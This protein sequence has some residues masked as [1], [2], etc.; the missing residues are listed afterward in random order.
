LPYD[1][2]RD[3][4]PVS[5]LTRAP[6]LLVVP[7]KSP[8]HSVHDLVSAARSAPGKLSFA[9]AGNG[10]AQHLT[11]EL[12]KQA[13]GTSMTHV[14]YKGGAPALTDL[15]G[16]QVGLMFSAT[17]A[18]GPFVQGGKLRA[19]AVTAGERVAG[20]PAVPT[21]KEAGV[22][23]MEVYEW[24]G[25]FAPAGTPPR[26]LERLEKEVRAAVTSP[27]LQRRWTELGVQGVGSS[28]A[29]FKGFLQSESKRWSGL[30]RSAGITIE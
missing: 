20:F 15:V 26:V 16:G 5:L 12:F 14:P 10:G 30:I 4:A 9:S 21:M 28:S 23:G 24:N 2:A 1:A 27:Q 7:E 18:S 22:P 3:F 8:L 17:S 25:L 6:L 29:D 11:G 13:T 19:L